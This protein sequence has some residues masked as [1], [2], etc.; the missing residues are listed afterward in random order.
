MPLTEKLSKMRFKS[1]ENNK[2]GLTSTYLGYF[3]TILVVGLIMRI[4]TLYSPITIF[5]AKTYYY[6]EG[7]LPIQK[8]M[9]T[10]I[11]AFY[12]RVFA[13]FLYIIAAI[14]IWFY[15]YHGLYEK[16]IMLLFITLEP[17]FLITSV[18]G[19]LFF[20]S[21]VL[22][23]AIYFI[24]KRMEN[25]IAKSII[26]GLL[27]GISLVTGPHVAFY[28]III[29]SFEFISKISK[30]YRLSYIIEKVEKTAEKIGKIRAYMEIA[31]SETLKDKLKSSEKKGEEILNKQ[32]KEFYEIISSLENPLN[33]N[34]MLT[35]MIAIVVATA[36]AIPFGVMDI[37]RALFWFPWYFV[38]PLKG[39]LSEGYVVILTVVLYFPIVLLAI[40]A[41]L[42]KE[43]EPSQATSFILLILLPINPYLGFADLLI[44]LYF[45][46]EAIV[47][48][49]NN[50]RETFASSTVFKVLVIVLLALSLY[51][52]AITVYA[53]HNGTEPLVGG[54]F[55][56]MEALDT[57][58]EY[59][60]LYS[61]IYPTVDVREGAEVVKYYV[62]LKGYIIDEFGNVIVGYNLS[63]FGE[64]YMYI[65]KIKVIEVQQNDLW[66]WVNPWKYFMRINTSEKFFDVALRLTE[67]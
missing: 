66:T 44:P 31:R 41:I 14:I 2:V 65:G 7:A 64:N 39:Y 3:L 21:F 11:P 42:F 38:G 37:V 47:K 54:A 15:G 1:K 60:L 58:K 46:F 6:A 25:T 48:N 17:H 28:L 4:Y 5:E 57:A 67:T 24:I 61:G 13:L 59:S 27:I 8:L 10:Y 49:I 50:F 29:L 35:V 53:S 9:L 56:D 12:L 23:L 55:I 32:K 30:A 51:Q 22:F 62:K 36:L 34:N 19:T 16:L 52:S 20:L 43:I 26:L 63:E 45:V 40:Y 33:A 18:F